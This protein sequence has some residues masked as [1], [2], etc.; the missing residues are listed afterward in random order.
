MPGPAPRTSCLG[1]TQAHA[2]LSMAVRKHESYH[3]TGIPRHVPF[4]VCLVYVFCAMLAAA[5]GN[6]ACEKANEG[7]GIPV[8]PSVRRQ[9]TTDELESKGVT[10]SSENMHL[11]DDPSRLTFLA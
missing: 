6:H 8:I 5:L 10:G 9:V 4:K 11:C 7:G 3:R 1:S 2:Q